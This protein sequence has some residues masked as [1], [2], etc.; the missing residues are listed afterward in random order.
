MLIFK[1]HIVA[2]PLYPIYPPTTACCCWLICCTDESIKPHGWDCGAT[3]VL[4]STKLC[5]WSYSTG[6]NLLITSNRLVDSLNWNRLSL[7]CD[8]VSITLMPDVENLHISI[9]EQTYW[10]IKED[11]VTSYK[12][13]VNRKIYIYVEKE[14]IV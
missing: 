2:C 10:N 1:D 13:N 8:T 7:V 12:L 6:S 14:I 5:F 4:L 3:I 11:F 9:I